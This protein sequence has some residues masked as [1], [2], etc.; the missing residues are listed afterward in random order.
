MWQSSDIIYVV[1]QLGSVKI[2]LMLKEIYVI[3]LDRFEFYFL[4]LFILDK[5]DVCKY[6]F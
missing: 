3:L 1:D 2:I 4:W 5:C 6:E